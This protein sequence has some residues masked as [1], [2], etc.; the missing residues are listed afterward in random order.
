MQGLSLSLSRLG[1]S[2][3][4][5][6]QLSLE[7]WESTTAARVLA[8]H[9]NTIEV[10]SEYNHKTI[11]LPGNWHM[12]DPEDLPTVG[13]WLLLDASTG[14]PQRLLERKS[15]FR[16]KAAGKEAKMQLLAANVD[17][18]FIVTSCNR[19]FNLS[20]LE[21]Y[22]A[23][24]LQAKVEPVLVLT[25]ADLVDD[26]SEY[27]RDAMGLKPDMA[28]EF[29]NALDPSSVASLVSWCA[30]GQTVALV[31][32]SGVG[33]STLINTLCGASTQVT[34]TIREEDAKG[35]HTTTSRT[36]HA[37]PMG[38]LLID[39]PGLRELQ[40]SDCQ[41]GVSSLFQDMEDL[42]QSCRFNDCLHQSEDGCA[43]KAA[44]ALGN[45]S[46]RRLA[47]YHK[48]MIEQKR[49][50]ESIAEKHRRERNFGK[51]IRAI[52]TEKHKERNGY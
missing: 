23:L 14:Q 4:F 40:L 42:A 17:S 2:H 7:E 25:K 3:Y 12:R 32:S 29:V 13:D 15:L 44:V 27:Q 24:A 43:V 1:W 48:L 35:R 11:T 38:G 52:L 21:R 16:R 37:L 31:G 34:G 5:Q 49:N 18:L 46:P 6:Q 22:L 8:V 36:L 20:R 51:H 45:L 39:S 30:N 50:A 41:N 10:A 9:R 28:V 26:V 47:N 33:K 19:D